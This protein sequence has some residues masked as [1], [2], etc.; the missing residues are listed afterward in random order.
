[1]T[2]NRT[3]DVSPFSIEVASHGNGAVISRV[4]CCDFQPS[5]QAVKPFA[6]VKPVPTE[7][8]SAGMNKYEIGYN[9]T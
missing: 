1:M 7:P 9:E 5:G 3:N 6:G 8:I 4:T 2:K